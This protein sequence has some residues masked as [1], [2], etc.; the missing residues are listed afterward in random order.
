[1]GEGRGNLLA[2]AVHDPVV[3]VEGQ[4][5]AEQ[6]P[7]ARLG[8]VVRR[9]TLEAYKAGLAALV[10]VEIL[11]FEHLLPGLL[12][13]SVVDCKDTAHVLLSRGPTLAL[14]GIVKHL[15]RWI[16]PPIIIDPLLMYWGEIAFG[17]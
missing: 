15:F 9:S 12:V 7:Q 17:N 1:M 4:L 11:P 10:L 3:A 16:N 8:T 13:D 6:A 5:V 2:A 14:H